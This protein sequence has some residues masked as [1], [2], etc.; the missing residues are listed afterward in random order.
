MLPFV[1]H[2]DVTDEV[3]DGT[4]AESS[5]AREAARTDAREGVERRVEVGGDRRPWRLVRAVAYD[6]EHPPPNPRSVVVRRRDARVATTPRNDHEATHRT[7]L[8]RTR[9][10][11]SPEERALTVTEACRKVGKA[12]EHRSGTRASGRGRDRRLQST[13]S[14]VLHPEGSRGSKLPARSS[15]PSERRR[16]TLDSEIGMKVLAEGRPEM[17][18]AEAG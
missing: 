6:R 8:C 5:E 16:E 9:D 4:K 17:P 15:I 11:H 14:L 13:G 1:P 10:A 18:P 7:A 2:R 3:F 12:P